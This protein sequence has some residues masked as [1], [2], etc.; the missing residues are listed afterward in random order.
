[1]VFGTGSRHLVP[2]ERSP[3]SAARPARTTAPFRGAVVAPVPGPSGTPPRH[4]VAPAPPV[5]RRPVVLG[6]LPWGRGD[7]EVGLARRRRGQG[8]RGCGQGRR[9]VLQLVAV[10]RGRAPAAGPPRPA[11]G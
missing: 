10:E 2:R 4:A 5:A 1:M 9:G 8:G 11:R 3:G 7:Q 6:V